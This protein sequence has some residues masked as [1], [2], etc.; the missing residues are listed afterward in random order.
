MCSFK[1]EIQILTLTKETMKRTLSHIKFFLF[2]KFFEFH[3]CRN[4]EDDFEKILFLISYVR[5]KD[6]KTYFDDL[7]LEYSLMNL[8]NFLNRIGVYTSWSYSKIPVVTSTAS[9]TKI[10]SC[11]YGKKYKVLFSSETEIS[12]IL[13]LEKTI[14]NINVYDVTN[15]NSLVL[16]EEFKI[17]HDGEER[18]FN[19]HSRQ[20]RM[21]TVI[22]RVMET[23]KKIVRN[24]KEIK[25]LNLSK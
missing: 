12:E 11:V 16:E 9:G 10:L 13:S 24:T 15:S 7:I 4:I 19:F 23:F 21:E 3:L 14:L 1:S 8:I 6:N 25:K 17:H 22:I 20:C 2:L 18:S 5:K